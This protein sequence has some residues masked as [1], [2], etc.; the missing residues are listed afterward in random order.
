M[1]NLIKIVKNTRW[2]NTHSPKKKENM[3]AVH[4]YTYIF[5]SMYQRNILRGAN[6][7]EHIVKDTKKFVVQWKSRNFSRGLN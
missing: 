4:I 6:D 1:E 2:K 7:Q 3:I 5:T